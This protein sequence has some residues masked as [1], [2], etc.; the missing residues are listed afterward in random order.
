MHYNY[1]YTPDFPEGREPFLGLYIGKDGP[2]HRIIRRS[3]VPDG[4]YRFITDAGRDFPYYVNDPLAWAP[5]PQTTTPPTPVEHAFVKLKDARPTSDMMHRL[6]L[7]KDEFDTLDELVK[8]LNALP[9]VVDDDYP[10]ARHYYDSALRTFL[11]A[12]AANGR[13]EQ[14]GYK[15]EK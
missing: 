8:K 13:L 6:H 9:A 2:E 15:I 12:C 14:I 7:Q 4:P 3:S 11:R 1:R 10:E 5:L